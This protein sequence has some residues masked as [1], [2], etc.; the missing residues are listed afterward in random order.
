MRFHNR[1][2]AGKLLAHRLQPLL[3]QPAVIYALPRGG[4]P[5]ASELA[6]ELEL[7]LEL[8]IVRK[9]GHPAQPERAVAAVAESGRAVFD[10]NERAHLDPAWL[11]QRIAAEHAE[12]QRRRRLYNDDHARVFAHGLCAVIVDDGIATGLSM[13]AAIAELRRDGPSRIIVAVP[14]APREAM[15]ELEKAVDAVVVA[16]LPAQFAGTVGAYYEDFHQ[17]DDD[18]V[19]KQLARTRAV[20]GPHFPAAA[21][22]AADQHSASIAHP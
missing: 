6:L 10:E 2:E 17:L 21:A 11:E 18:E 22:Q 20:V 15:L 12:A 8:V 5:V 3:Q 14:V 9:I 13:Q 4:V 1:R 16:Q 7:P 19:L